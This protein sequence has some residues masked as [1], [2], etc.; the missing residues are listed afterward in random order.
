MAQAI[1]AAAKKALAD[2]TSTLDVN[3]QLTHAVQDRFLSRV[4]LSPR[5]SEWL[6][7]GGGAMLAR[8]PDT[9]ATKD[10][11]LAASV[12]DLE[13]AQEALEWAVQ[14]DAG[15]H[16]RFDLTSSKPTG[17]GG[18]Q[19]GVQTRR[20]VFT[21]VDA[22]SGRKVGTVPVDVVVGP[23]PVGQVESRAPGNRLSLPR[24]VPAPSYRL[25]P[26]TDQ[27]AEK[28]C[29]TLQDYN[30][31]SS[32]RVKD[33]VDLVTIAQ[34]QRVD[35]NELHR[36]LENKRLYSELPRFEE[37]VVPAGWEQ[38]FRV[39]ASSTR[40][41]DGVTE[42]PAAVGLVS[43]LVNP[44]LGGGAAQTWVPGQGWVAGP[45]SDGPDESTNNSRGSVHVDPHV[46]NGRPVREHY[47]GPRSS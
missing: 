21:C 35:L 34:T 15:D 25:F 37:F 28:V 42:L 10:L 40:S 6:L 32:T 46:R 24:P 45:G 38:P 7:K 27:I 5:S 1:K 26:V 3:A 17:L 11:D 14:H 39:L 18:N 44:A 2:G 43:R 9:R 41:V 29:A 22:D 47:R 31:R 8:V 20:L 12:K 33:L 4:F 16:L 36:A 23:A 19:P 30:G 13:E